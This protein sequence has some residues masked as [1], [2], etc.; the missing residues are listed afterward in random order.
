ML[1]MPA[2]FTLSASRETSLTIT[3]SP[4]IRS[5]VDTSRL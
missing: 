4:S 5:S 3:A 2:V 1:A